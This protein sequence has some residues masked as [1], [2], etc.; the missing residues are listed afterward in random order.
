MYLG[1]KL[2]S[3]LYWLGGNDRRLALFENIYPLPQGICYN[4]YLL[5]DEKN[6]LLD[7]VDHGVE[8][9]LFANLEKLL[10]GSTLDY[11]VLQHLEPDHSAAVLKLIKRYPRAA[12][13]TS[14][15]GAKF[16]HQFFG[17]LPG[18]TIKTVHEGEQLSTGRHTFTFV[19]A[20]MVH[21]P[22]VMVTYDALEQI[23][24]SAD[25]F[26]SFGALS[27][28]VYADAY[29]FEHQ[30]LPEARRYY[31]NIVGKYGPQVQNLLKKAASLKIKMICPLHGPIWRENLGWFI[32]KYQRWSSYTPEKAAVLIAYGSIYGR[33]AQAAE[34]LAACLAQKGV[35]DLALYDVSVTHPSYLVAEAFRCSHLVFASSTYNNGL[36]DPME[37]LLQDLATHNLQNRRAA[38]IE[39]GTWAP[40]AGKLMQSKLAALKSWTFIEPRITLHSAAQEP[41]EKQLEQLAENIVLSLKETKI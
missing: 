33:T 28:N 13:V 37:H 11:V 38:L 9:I 12:I 21:W 5:Q 19:M 36:F 32:E 6:I 24:F 10:A 1:Q 2:T 27:G 22:E 35:R 31:T 3:D 30:W 20:P 8:D 15:L 18:V 23:L 40:T 26:G 25:A 4:T 16:L 34:Y 29:D 41:Q 7:C 14:V 39:N 17:E